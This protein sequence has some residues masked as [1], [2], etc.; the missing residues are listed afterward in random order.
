MATQIFQD[1]RV[2][3]S[4]VG[5]NG[6][7]LV[8]QD[9]NVQMGT[10][11]YTGRFAFVRNTYPARYNHVVRNMNTLIAQTTEKEKRSMRGGHF[12]LYRYMILLAFLLCL[13]FGIAS[14]YVK[15]CAVVS[16]PLSFLYI[17]L[18]IYN[19]VIYRLNRPLIHRD[20]A[21][22]LS[23][24]QMPNSQKKNMFYTVPLH[25]NIRTDALGAFVDPTRIVAAVQLEHTHVDNID[26]MFYDYSYVRDARF[27]KECAV[28]LILF[29]IMFILAIIFVSTTITSG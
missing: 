9:T 23:P 14:I 29:I 20:L 2:H 13:A 6:V 11:V 8:A 16:F 15:A 21:I 22:E 24:G 5:D 18:S 7:I 28:H 12:F 17:F 26:I 27:P 1:K 10:P 4:T 3:V 19:I 25:T